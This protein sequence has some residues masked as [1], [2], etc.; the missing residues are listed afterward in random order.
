[1]NVVLPY[2]SL[3]IYLIYEYS[4]FTKYYPD[5]SAGRIL[6]GER[7]FI[8]DGRS[9]CP[10]QR[11]STLTPPSA[12]KGICRN[13]CP[14]DCRSGLVTRDKTMLSIRKRPHCPWRPILLRDSRHWKSNRQV[15]IPRKNVSL[16][17]RLFRVPPYWYPIL[18]QYTWLL[19]I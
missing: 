8:L 16:G 19:M 13:D 3:F 12:G 18:M 11:K 6:F 14:C 2:E 15:T 17:C 1:M 7:P 5:E 9:E 4:R 10:F